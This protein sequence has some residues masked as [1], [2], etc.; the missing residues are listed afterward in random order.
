M[1]LIDD[2]PYD[3]NTI[4]D[5]PMQEQT[6][7]SVGCGQNCIQQYVFRYLYWLVP[8][9]IYK[10][11]VVGTGVHKGMEI[12]LDPSLPKNLTAR[13][14]QALA[15]IDASF[16]KKYEEPEATMGSMP[17]QLEHGRAQA[18]ACVTAWALNFYNDL[19]FKVIATEVNCRCEATPHYYKNK[20][21]PSSDEFRKRMAGKLDGQVEELNTLDAYLLEH[22]ALS[23]IRTI[24][25][26]NAL[27]MNHQALW[28]LIL[29]HGLTP[30][31]GFYY[32]VMAKPAHKVGKNWDD[33]RNRMIEAM[34]GDTE[35]YFAMFP[36]TI[37]EDKLIRM[38][39]NWKRTLHR[40]D[41]LTP[42]TVEMNLGA[43]G[44]YSGCPYKPLCRN[45]VDAG[46][47]HS[48][49]DTPEIEM[50]KFVEPHI[51]LTE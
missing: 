12:L 16:A 6:Q 13:L 8:R 18:H 26:G 42:D 21:G 19:P 27:E 4:F 37:E 35:K 29:S 25:W 46:C 38:E 40:L 51:E 11:F 32:N 48:V 33:L 22:K 34:C 36:V 20:D 3:L 41:T 50:F 47:P 31:K 49:F 44:A 39:N 14:P 1:P 45:L 15:G 5:H 30:A 2:I 9:A 7:S 43:C 28:Y 23:S 24:D 17:A 10:P